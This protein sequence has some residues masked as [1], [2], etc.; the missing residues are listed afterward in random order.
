MAGAKIEK[1]SFGW[2]EKKQIF[3]KSAENTVSFWRILVFLQ[4]K[5]I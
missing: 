4:H 2:R 5:T 3:H 1:I